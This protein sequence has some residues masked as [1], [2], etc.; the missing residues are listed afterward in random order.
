MA[1]AWVKDS[2]AFHDPEEDFLLV[3]L[4][5]IPESKQE[6]APQY[7]LEP[8]MENF[9]DRSGNASEIQL[10]NILEP[11]PARDWIVP[12]PRPEST[13]EPEPE[14]VPETHH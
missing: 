12:E 2:E 7:V 13:L 8:W 4:G 10:E 3:V 1:S 14:N 11:S 6:S 9:L 5:I